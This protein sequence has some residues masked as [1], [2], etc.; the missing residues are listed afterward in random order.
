MI[1]ARPGGVISSPISCYFILGK[2][3]LY[4]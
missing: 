3:L 1:A 4:A 2:G